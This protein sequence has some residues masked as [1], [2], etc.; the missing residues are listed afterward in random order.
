MACAP[1]ASRAS[2]PTGALIMR[3][4]DLRTYQDVAAANDPYRAHTIVRLPLDDKV[5]FSPQP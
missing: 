5:W 1:T 2:R 3:A 4:Y